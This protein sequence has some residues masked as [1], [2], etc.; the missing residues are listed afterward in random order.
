MAGA[1]QAL[2]GGGVALHEPPT[3]NPELV[4]PQELGAELH[5][6]AGAPPPPPPPPLLG[7]GLQMTRV[8]QATHV[9]AAPNIAVALKTPPNAVVIA[10]GA[11]TATTT[12]T[13]TKATALPLDRASTDAGE[14]DTAKSTTITRAAAHLRNF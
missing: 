10:K 13:T 11:K 7:L 3:M 1:G 9:A 5:A 2:F 12:A 4:C 8:A 6:R 14:A